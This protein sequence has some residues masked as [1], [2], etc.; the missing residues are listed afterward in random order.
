MG[1]FKLG[2]IV[3]VLF[4]VAIIN[5]W[6]TPDELIITL[7]IVMG[8][9]WIWSRVSLRRL[10]F[11][12]S[13]SLDRV[14]AG[15][16]VR[17][18]L[19][20]M[21]YAVLP[22]LWVEC[23]DH[24]TL[25]GYRAGRV[26][27]LRTRG[28][29]RWAVEARC[30]Q[31]GRFR[32]GP[33]TI[34]SGDPLGLFQKETVIPATHDL[35]VYPVALDVSGVPLPA[36]NMSGGRAT[37]RSMAIAAHT[38]SGL[39]EYAPGDPLNR[40]S[41]NA[42][43]RRGQ[44]MVKEFD[45]DPTSDLWVLVDLGGHWDRRPTDWTGVSDF[46]GRDGASAFVNTT[47]EAVIALAASLAE[48]ALNEGRKVGLL[49]NRA[50]PIRLD[51]DNSQRQWFRIFETLAL[52]TAFGQRSLTEAIAGDARKF[53]RTSGLVVVTASSS[54]DW[55]ASAR[56]L[57]QR[58][59]PVTAVMVEGAAHESH[60]DFGVLIED[61]SAAHVVLSRFDAH[62]RSTHGHQSAQRPVT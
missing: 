36:A 45:P 52:A 53:S 60:S 18:E 42:T 11:S 22:K 1:G 43:A 48:R 20:L 14:R 13:L 17:E 15:E 34:R 2:L 61:L 57:V 58:Q 56:A 16:L 49:V 8:I 38:I 12:R 33:V 21:N 26:V 23:L 10:G 62:G 31:R 46:D 30:L 37:N 24:S 4:I 55:V 40:I 25:P 6:S 44:M 47:E 7:L 28:E 3:A 32:L 9:A 41:W 39:R 51:P 19:S 5:D 50:M 27:R 54:R 35:I 29:A 59:V